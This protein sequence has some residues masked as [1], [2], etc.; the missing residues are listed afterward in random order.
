MCPVESASAFRAIAY[1][2]AA[3]KP[4][5]RHYVP[6]RGF[7]AAVQPEPTKLTVYITANNP[8]CT[9]KSIGWVFDELFDAQPRGS[10]PTDNA[11]PNRGGKGRVFIFD[12]ANANPKTFT[13]KITL[14]VTYTC[15]DENGKDTDYQFTWS[16]FWVVT[17]NGNTFRP[18]SD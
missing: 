13:V 12:H 14:T 18:T 3:E 6:F 4:C 7:N 10:Q 2:L 1:R 9:V 17:A 8:K 16:F 5:V 15:P 11:D